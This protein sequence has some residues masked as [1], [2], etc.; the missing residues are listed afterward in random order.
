MTTVSKHCQQCLKRD[1]SFKAVTT[2]YNK[3]K[4]QQWHKVSNITFFWKQW[5]QFSNSNNSLQEMTTVSEHWAQFACS[6]NK[7]KIICKGFE[8][9]KTVSKQILHL[10]ISETVTIVVKQWQLFPNSYTIYKR[11]H[12]Y[13][14]WSVSLPPTEKCP[15]ATN[16]LKVTGARAAGIYGRMDL[17]MM[18]QLNNTSLFPMDLHH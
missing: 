4:L 5:Q 3:K 9:V 17:T 15:L 11:W 7:F 8:K 12:Q 6:D 14:N 13:Q 1:S 10:P 18:A 16:I 2:V